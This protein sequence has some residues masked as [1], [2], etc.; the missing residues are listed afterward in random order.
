METRALPQHLP[1]YFL[2]MDFLLAIAYVLATWSGHLEMVFGLDNENNIPTWYSSIQYAFV[3]LL[4]SI[5]AWAQLRRDDLA[6]WALCVPPCLFLLLSL[7]EQASMHERIGLFFDTMLFNG[8][9][10]QNVLPVSG[11]WVFIA[12]PFALVAFTMLRYLHA[13]FAVAPHAYRLCAIGLVTIVFAAAGLEAASNLID[14]NKSGMLP[15]Y[16]EILLEET[17]EM[18]GATLVL[19]GASELINAHGITIAVGGA[20]TK[21]RTSGEQ[22]LPWRGHVMTSGATISRRH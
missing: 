18:I 2:A 15:L 5:V 1:L 6:S 19:W 8:L 13:C 9:G 17:L 7:D 12:V 4:F 22:T 3:A 20:E 16:T 14:V 11:L 10:E 21:L